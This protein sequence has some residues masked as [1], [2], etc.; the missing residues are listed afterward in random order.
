MAKVEITAPGIKKALSGHNY[1]RAFAEFIRDGF[2]AKG[3]RLVFI[4]S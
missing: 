3:A 4:R 2:D 1:L